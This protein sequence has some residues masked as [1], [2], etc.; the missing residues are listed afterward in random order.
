MN[1]NINTNFSMGEESVS[2]NDVLSHLLWKKKFLKQLGNN[3]DTKFHQDNISAILLKANGMDNSSKRT[4]HINIR[5]FFIKNHIIRKEL[6]VKQCS[7]Y[8][9]LADFPIKPLQTIKFNIFKRKMMG[10]KK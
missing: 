5:L 6:N 1:R 9:M 7:T 10:M 2:A 3:Y 4:R 8:D